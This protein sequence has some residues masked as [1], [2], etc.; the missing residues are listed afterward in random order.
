[1]KLPS[2]YL[3]VTSLSRGKLLIFPEGL[4]LSPGEFPS[5]LKV[6]NFSS[7]DISSSGLLKLVCPSVRRHNEM[8]SLWMQLLLQFL[9]NLFET[10]QAFLSWSEDVHLVWGLSSLFFINFFHFY[11]LSFFQVRSLLE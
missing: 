5:C 3:K 6:T 4:L 7:P 2:Y 9:T 11:D 8:G 10:L 1:M